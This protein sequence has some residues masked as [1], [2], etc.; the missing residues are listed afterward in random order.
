MTLVINLVSRPQ[1]GSFPRECQEVTLR[2]VAI[3]FEKNAWYS[4]FRHTLSFDTDV[5]SYAMLP[6]AFAMKALWA[7]D[8]TN[9]AKG[10]LII[11]LPR[12]IAGRNAK[13]KPAK[14]CVITYFN[15]QKE[16]VS[17]ILFGP[18]DEFDRAISC[19]PM[20]RQTTVLPPA[21]DK[22]SEQ[23]PIP[24]SLLSP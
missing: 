14:A 19:I 20:D 21:F 22:L 17:F 8:Q 13:F 18:P 6:D 7:W 11:A 24:A 9:R 10:P 4:I 1:A 15:D 3:S 23:A 16:L 12:A 5:I 2:G